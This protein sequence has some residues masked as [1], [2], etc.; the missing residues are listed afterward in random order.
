[1]P[2]TE[3]LMARLSQLEQGY[4]GDK[5][6]ARKKQ[7]FDTYGARFSNNQGLGL[8]ILNELDAR[9][10]DTSAADEAV[11]EILDNLRTDCNEI[12]NLIKGVQE[13]AIDNAQKVETIA[14]VVQEQ[15]AANPEASTSPMG[16]DPSQLAPADLG[17][18]DTMDPNGEFNP[19][20]V[21][22]EGDVG[23]EEELPPPPPAAEEETPPEA[24]GEE[25]P[26]EEETPPE[27]GGEEL[28]PEETLSDERMKNIAVKKRGPGTTKEDNHWGETNT[29]KKK[30]EQQPNKP[31]SDV[32][33]RRAEEMKK[34][35]GARKNTVSDERLKNVYK[36]SAG[37]LSA[38]GGN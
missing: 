25:L 8:A 38:C 3:E 29:Q 22:P 14:N 12:L 33:K 1:M 28:P 32:A 17:A 2:G 27:A 11:G 36:P 30:P 20:A 21:V 37:I 10:I 13:Q 34:R 23:G 31:S 24:G 26:P 18:L 6:A 15:I 35:W 7:F 16:P 4:Y 19:D 5:E 9:G